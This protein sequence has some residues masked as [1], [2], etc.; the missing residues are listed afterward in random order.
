MFSVFTIKASTG[1]TPPVSPAL[2]CTLLLCLQYFGIYLMQF[3]CQTYM[4]LVSVKVL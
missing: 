1:A 2:L 3:F 4:L